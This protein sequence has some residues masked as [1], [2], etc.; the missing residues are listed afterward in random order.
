MANEVNANIRVDVDTS[1]ALAS[2]R[3][4]QAQI[5]KFNQ[6]VVS[7]NS[8]ATAAQQSMLNTLRAQIGASGEFSTS[9]VNVRGNVSRLQNAIDKN[10][11]SLGEY[12]RYGAASSR[13]FGRMF[14]R[15]HAEVMALA[16]ERVKKLQTQYIALGDAAGG[17]T[18]TLAVK[19]MSLFNADMAIG[20]Q[21]TQ[22]FNKFLTDGTTQLI[23]FGKNTQ[24]AGRQLMVGFT[25]PLTIFGAAASRIFIDLEKQ[26]I[27]FRKVY[28]DIFTTEAETEE[29]LQSIRSLSLEFTKYGIAVK[30]SME[31][32]SIAAQAGFRGEQLTAATTQATRLAVLGQMQQ[33]EAMEATI[34]LQTAFALSNEQLAEAVNFLNIT[35]NQ[36]VLSLQDVAGAIPRVAPV[37]NSLGGDV[38]DLA[39]LLVAMKEGGVSAAE[40]ANALKNS[41]GRLI[42]PTSAAKKMAREFGI[43]LE[44]I[45]TRNEGKVMP[46]LAELAQTMEG[47]SGLEQ[48][49]L[50]STIFGK[51]QYA[52]IGALFKSLQDDAS[53]ASRVLQLTGMSVEQLAQT[54]ED[55]LAVVEE[56]VS[57]KFV[58]ALERAKVAIAPV[59]ELF[60]KL[61]TPI[62]NGIS[63]IFEKF[64]ELSPNVKNF[65]AILVTGLGVIT[66][67]MIMLIGLTAN[68]IGNIVKGLVKFG[69]FMAKIKG[70]GDAVNYLSNEQI[71]AAAAA[72]SLEG[73]VDGLTESLASQL[74][75]ISQLSSAYQRYT[76]AAQAAAAN[77]PQGFRSGAAPRKMASGGM[78]GGV[79]NTDS[80][81]ALLTP[82]EFVMNKEATQQFLPILDSMNRGIIKG[83][84]DGSRSGYSR[85]ELIAMTQR[86]IQSGRAYSQTPEAM[87]YRQRAASRVLIP[88]QQR[89]GK[90][91]IGEQLLKE[92]EAKLASMQVKAVESGA[93]LSSGYANGIQKGKPKV[94][95]AAK[96]VTSSAIQQIKTTQK[97]SSDSLI[98]I[99]EGLN[100]A[101]GYATGIQQGMPEVQ[102]AAQKM[103]SG[104]LRVVGDPKYN[105]KAYPETALR[106]QS[107]QQNM[108][109]RAGA[110]SVEEVLPVM[111]LR[112]GEAAGI[113][114]TQTQVARGAFDPIATQLQSVAQDFVNEVNAEFDR[115]AQTIKNSDERMAAAWTYAGKQVE[116]KISQLPAQ[117]DQKVI[118]RYVGLDPDIYGTIPTDVRRAGDT[119]LT[120]ARKPML[121]VG[122]QGRSYTA[123][124]TPARALFE[125]MTG[126]SAAAM[127]MGHIYGPSMINLQE[128][129]KNN[130]QVTS[131]VKTAMANIDR[132]AQQTGKSAAENL[133]RP[134][135]TE[136]KK[137]GQQVGPNIMSGAKAA[138]PPPWSR[139]LGGWIGQGIREGTTTQLRMMPEEIRRTISQGVVGPTSPIRGVPVSTMGQYIGVGGAGAGGGGGG[140]EF[141]GM[142][143]SNAPDDFHKS[144]ENATKQTNRFSKTMGSLRGGAVKL[145][146]MLRG[147]SGALSAAT[148]GLSSLT[149]GL[150]MMNNSVGE[151][152]QKLMPFV[153]G[154]TAVQQILPML[155][156]P[157]G[158][159]IVGVTALGI[160]AYVLSQKMKEM[161]QVGTRYIEALVGSAEKIENMA[162]ELGTTTFKQKLT[163][164]TSQP[165]A[166]ARPTEETA[167]RAAEFVQSE[168]GK[169][170]LEDI[171]FITKTSGFNKGVQALKNQLQRAILSGVMD[172]KTANAIAI[173]VA[174]QLQDK[175]YSIDVISQLTQILGPNGE[176]LKTVEGRIQI[177]A[178]II[179]DVKGPADV[180]KQAEDIF[181][182]AG[183]LGQT[184]LRATVLGRGGFGS[185]AEAQA[186]VQ[187][188]L[189]AAQATQN[190]A[191]LRDEITKTSVDLFNSNIGFDEFIE[192]NIRLNRSLDKQ[193]TGWRAVS[194]QISN[195][196][197]K[198]LALAN[199][200]QQGFEKTLLD[201]SN[202]IVKQ[203]M[204][205][206]KQNLVFDQ[207]N[208]FNKEFKL[209]FAVAI[210]SG[211]LDPQDAFTFF[212]NLK[213]APESVQTN[214]KVALE[215][216]SGVEA[217][218]L[219]NLLAATDGE[220]SAD[221]ILNLIKGKDVGELYK[222]NAIAEALNQA[223]INPKLFLT[224]PSDK[225]QKAMEKINN[226]VN[227]F[228]SLRGKKNVERRADFLTENFGLVEGQINT[229]D[230]M[231]DTFQKRVVVAISAFFAEGGDKLALEFLQKMGVKLTPK[232]AEGKAVI[233]LATDYVIRTQADPLENLPPKEP[234]GGDGGGTKS[235]LQQFLDDLNAN[236]RL[237]LDANKG[238]PGYLKHRAKFIGYLRELRKM[239]VPESVIQSLS[240][241]EEGLKQ[242]QALLTLGD[243][244]MATIAKQITSNTLGFFME[245]QLPGQKEEL[246]AKRDAQQMLMQR[247]VTESV[248]RDIASDSETALLLVKLAATGTKK[249]LNDLIASLVEVQSLSTTPQEAAIIRIDDLRK[250]TIN[251]LNRKEAMFKQTFG[252]LERQY[253]PLISANR[254]RIQQLQDQITLVQKQID[255][256]ED[257]N[258]ADQFRIRSLERQKEMLNRQVE[259]VE[260]QNEIDQR[261]IDT[262]KREDEIRNRVSEALSKDLEILSQQEEKIREAYDK[263]FKALDKVAKLNDYIINQQK[264]QLNLSRAISE[265]DIYAATAAA[266]E[267]R[268][269][270]AQFSVE[271]TRAG[272]EAGME[273]QIAG[274]TTAGGLTRQQAEQQINQIK[275]QSYQT[276]LLVR[277]VEDQ[278][279]NRNLELLPLKEQIRNIDDQ[280]RSIN[281]V[282]YER[283]T[284]VLQIQMQK[285]EP[286]QAQLEAE[287]TSLQNNERA[288]ADAKAAVTIEGLTYEELE[289]Q[290][291]AEKEAYD[292]AVALIKTNQEQVKSV[293]N[294]VR[295][296]KDVTAQ[297]AAANRTA[298][299]LKEQAEEISQRELNAINADLARGLI[300][301]DEASRRIAASNERRSAA[302][303]NVEQQRI[304]DI[305]VFRQSGM[306][307]IQG[308]YMGG[309]INYKGSREPAPGM[310]MGGK[311]KKYP[312]GGL[313]PYAMGGVAGDGGRDSVLAKLTPG[314]F[315]IRKAMVKKYGESMMKDINMGSF[316][317]PRYNAPMS[318]NVEMTRVNNNNVIAPVYNNYDMDFAISGSNASADEIAN[319]VMFKIKQVQSSAIR[320]NRG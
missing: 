129:Q 198:D 77:L 161:N 226:L 178:D 86:S 170:L 128:V 71:E 158:A 305:E 99:Q 188:Q 153:F 3:Q 33:Q 152:A 242:A 297:I 240:E 288:L 299:Q 117:V 138:S 186:I 258:K 278:I 223:G 87:A 211:Q 225:Q 98:G 75:V 294:L 106:L 107:A 235:W 124:R 157:W 136:S 57:T 12:F 292:V 264:Q 101:S 81:P 310:S 175:R 293:E 197:G 247:G 168:T 140:G 91:Y 257:L 317:V 53:Q 276:S 236:S 271:Q 76:S 218:I 204:S 244:R 130:A 274:L 62:L 199:Q 314:E 111:A 192:N 100:L 64:N 255:E 126:R 119:E 143:M 49:Q 13:T 154:I 19:P 180:A 68:F 125:R 103:T 212:N 26:A 232:E 145:G 308:K 84:A 31:L 194:E 267:M 102:S 97:S 208:K 176:Q 253:Q 217:S 252:E 234:P 30:D 259:E 115:T 58:A 5:S 83:F 272:L 113:K 90:Q 79:G 214:V 159:L 246:V 88:G 60:L 66:P 82:G 16:T 34:S 61:A 78:V 114:P 38:K 29:A 89:G 73:R 109:R 250:A 55:E 95:T 290:I 74:N 146:G 243:K 302:L 123:L 213:N 56:S 80:Q 265:G 174:N 110:V 94:D 227:E 116:Q 172:Q 92:V 307:A 127:Q 144:V 18:R 248:A 139:Q 182:N 22:L 21:R 269:Q 37:I 35:E 296:W 9:L 131:A 179:A 206:E 261:R 149:F 320:T 289:N 17:M 256:I 270:S 45:V 25:I 313:I 156:N 229:F 202:A 285:L 7:S 160:G 318:P 52:R 224:L 27:T 72:A 215:G 147:G 200:A 221:V 273:G 319:K 137:A 190:Y 216:L 10:R 50:L 205:L 177:A 118:R 93:S 266:Q 183:M 277:D 151:T 303:R 162:K 210:T 181:M 132:L 171:E 231:P 23:N 275:E 167:S 260:R 281:D 8:R 228:D 112:A 301:P 304:A 233:R 46:M 42:V 316:S 2:L 108:A 141:L 163:A 309:R 201:S 15:E 237:Y 189:L 43:D 298:R 164:I 165:L 209:D 14:G 286:L 51:F 251:D 207:L 96:D 85:E 185:G 134:I 284:Q 245:K 36:S 122:E 193:T 287:Q 203:S 263:R 44:G 69:Q 239:G 1:A 67:V 282:I 166:V 4:L 121:R 142:P 191:L 311:I 32:A 155:L 268:A 47:L 169:A 135:V 104:A 65:I 280:I 41:L 105:V 220:L 120:R 28:G 254:K 315:V 20:I 48:Q 173:E 295:R 63:K 40:G 249:E 195:Y 306:N 133:T 312:M 300:K 196:Y 279:Y 219:F 24:W 184:A 283:E 6:S 241:G 59:G 150:S 222:I 238:F 291:S 54:A 39:V 230:A 262:L 70:G 148:I 11:L 187:G